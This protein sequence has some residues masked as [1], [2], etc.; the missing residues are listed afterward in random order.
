MSKKVSNEVNGE[1]L[2]LKEVSE[3][4]KEGG[5]VVDIEEQVMISKKDNKIRLSVDHSLPYI[6]LADLRFVKPN[7]EK[8]F[9]LD[10]I[11][12]KKEISKEDNLEYYLEFEFAGEYNPYPHLITNDS[13]KDFNSLLRFLYENISLKDLW[14]IS[15][16]IK[17]R[18]LK[19][20]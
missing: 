18:I 11:E 12:L 14:C 4:L 2:N 9:P 17:V 8:I 5:N 13:F 20:N 1:L 7:D 10:S 6:Y 3:I 15:S 16:M 19:S